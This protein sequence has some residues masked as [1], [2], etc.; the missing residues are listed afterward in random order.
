MLEWV[1]VKGIPKEENEGVWTGG[2][3][4]VGFR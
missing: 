4:V 2:Q 3:N 1:H